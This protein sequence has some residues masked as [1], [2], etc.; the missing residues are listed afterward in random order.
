VEESSSSSYFG[1]KS[2]DGYVVDLWYY[3]EGEK[4]SISV[5]KEA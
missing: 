5:E 4:L 2:A 3:D 1:G